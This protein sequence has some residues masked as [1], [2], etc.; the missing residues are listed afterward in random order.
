MKH[1]YEDLPATAFWRTGAADGA[2]TGF[3][4]LHVPKFTITSDTKVA[5]AGSCFAQHIGQALRGAGIAVLDAE[6]R[7]TT[8]DE[9]ICRRFGYGLFS[10][11]YGNIYTA[12]QMTQLL[13]DVA[14]GTV[15]PRFVW[16]KGAGFVDALRPTVEPDGLASIDEVLLH[17]AYH[18][19]RTAQML[20]VADVFIF[21]LGL[22]EAWEDLETGRVFPMCPGTV[23]GTF[24]AASHAFRNFT[25]AEILADL[26]E[27]RAILQR[28]NPDMQVLLTVSPVP[29]TATASGDHVIPATAYSKAVLCAAAGEAV[30]QFNDMDYFPSFEIITSHVMGGPWFDDDQRTVRPEGVAQVM[31]HFLTAHGL[32]ALPPTDQPTSLPDGDISYDD[33]DLICDELLLD[34]FEK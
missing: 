24:D 31:Q 32:S 1:P 26:H 34:A 3:A 4:R 29:L 28:F 9:T 16:P 8:M 10:G 17:R 6:A 12:R 23:A 19:E 33:A 30:I 7:P 5:T 14:Q 2:A 11:R 27:I 25:H 21:T 22:T 15:D 13:Q 20:R 18:L